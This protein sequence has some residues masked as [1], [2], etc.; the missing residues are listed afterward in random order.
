VIE[1][2]K[3]SPGIVGCGRLGDDVF[4]HWIYPAS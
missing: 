3:P 1:R 2:I 4:N